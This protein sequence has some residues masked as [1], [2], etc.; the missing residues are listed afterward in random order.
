[1][2]RGHADLS[3]VVFPTQ[4]HETVLTE[5]LEELTADDDVLG[6]L[7]SGSLARGTARPDSDIDVNVV[8]RANHSVRRRNFGPIVVEYGCRSPETWKEHFS[9]TRVGDESW[10]YAFVD[11]VILY[12]PAGIV[13]ELIETAAVA[14]KTYRTPHAIKEHYAW[15]WNHVRVK[16]EAVLAGGD[17]TEVGWAAA[18]MTQ[19]V[20]QS[21][22]AVNK[23]PLPS[24]DLGCFQRHLDDLRLPADVAGLI[25]AMLAAPPAEALQIQLQIVDAVMPHLNT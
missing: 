24:L 13:A 21:V 11:G 3:S 15:L 19:Y 14:L 6:A 18:V 25:R 2:T 22:W 8:A 1:M 23:P 7:L 5:V 16:M 4:L 10:A 20:I 17:A 9:P 12:D